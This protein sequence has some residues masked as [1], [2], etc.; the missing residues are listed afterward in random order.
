MATRL[1]ATLSANEKRMKRNSARIE[2]DEKFNKRK[3]V[4]QVHFTKL[5]TLKRLPRGKSAKK[6]WK[7]KI[8][9]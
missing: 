4:S 5:E 9:K 7:K 2:A 3:P 8:S 1:E 6:T